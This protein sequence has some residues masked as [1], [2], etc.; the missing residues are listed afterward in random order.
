[1]HVHTHIQEDWMDAAE[2]LTP[3]HV[4]SNFWAG[5]DSYYLN[6]A[7][8]EKTFFCAFVDKTKQHT[9]HLAKVFY[10]F[11]LGLD[12]RVPISIFKN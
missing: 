1:M 7:F 4:Q 9:Q 2:I 8:D 6:V 12:V 10:V 11:Y 5:V 3:A